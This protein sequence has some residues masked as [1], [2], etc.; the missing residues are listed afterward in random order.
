MSGKGK[1][2]KAST[3]ANSAN[4]ANHANKK[5]A[6]AATATTAD[7]DIATANAAE[8]QNGDRYES[9]LEHKHTTMM[10]DCKLNPPNPLRYTRRKAEIAMSK[11][12]VSSA[13]SSNICCCFSG[14]IKG[15]EKRRVTDIYNILCEPNLRTI[16]Q[17]FITGNMNC[18]VEYM[19][20]IG[21]LFLPEREI[22]AS[23]FNFT[24]IPLTMTRLPCCFSIGDTPPCCVI[25]NSILM[26][27]MINCL[28]ARLCMK[29]FPDLQEITMEPVYEVAGYPQHGD[30]LSYTAEGIITILMKFEDIDDLEKMHMHLVN[31]TKNKYDGKKFVFKPLVQIMALK[32]HS[33]KQIGECPF[34]KNHEI[35]KM[36]IINR[37]YP[38]MSQLN[39]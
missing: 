39:A 5:E 29:L 17:S 22:Y 1:S 3:K 37:L 4:K 36:Q 30:D 35:H 26:N 12:N 6:R 25:E 23:Q 21:A 27:T 20:Q 33:R 14:E 15:D 7:V 11:P 18:E 2:K 9:T 8:S 10:C 31:K 34:K 24:G 38:T 32:P 28:V 13:L 19:L 16:C